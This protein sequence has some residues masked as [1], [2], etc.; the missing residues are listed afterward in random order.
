MVKQKA[1]SQNEENFEACDAKWIDN[2]HVKIN[3]K[4]VNIYEGY[5]YRKNESNGK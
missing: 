3:G 5:D 4:V 2:N 1:V